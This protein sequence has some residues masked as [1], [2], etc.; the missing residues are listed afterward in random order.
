M[1]V[2][3]WDQQNIE[4]QKGTDALSASTSSGESRR[5]EFSYSLLE[6]LLF[7][8]QMI[9]PDDQTQMQHFHEKVK[10]MF[11]PLFSSGLVTQ[12]MAHEIL[13]RTTVEQ[14]GMGNAE[15]MRK[16]LIQYR[17]FQF[18]AQ[19]KFNLMREECEGFSK[20]IIELNQENINQTTLP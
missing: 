13:D 18:Y 11:L 2:D 6:S 5:D 9:Q 7:C 12:Q 15:I 1:E 19:N 8:K 4:E 16:C 10:G 14:I 17:T 3:E 20:L